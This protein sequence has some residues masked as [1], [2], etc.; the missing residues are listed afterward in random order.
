MEKQFKSGRFQISDEFAAESKSIAVCNILI[1][2]NEREA[3]RINK[4]LGKEDIL[5]K[6][7]IIKLAEILH[8]AY[9]DCE[10]VICPI[11]EQNEYPYESVYEEFEGEVGTAMSSFIS[12]LAYYQGLVKEH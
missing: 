2:I 11:N 4:Y 7:K 5:P 8:K 1:R 6:E 9:E 12:K 3:Q 10:N